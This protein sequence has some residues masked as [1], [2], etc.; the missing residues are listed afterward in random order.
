MR[1][2]GCLALNQC[3]VIYLHLHK[4]PLISGT[5]WEDTEATGAVEG[6]SNMLQLTKE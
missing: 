5:E 1:S 4:E 2:K 3:V 6:S